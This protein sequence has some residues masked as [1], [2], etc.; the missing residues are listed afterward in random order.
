[1]TLQKK[2]ILSQFCNIDSELRVVIATVAL[3][4]GV[5]C[6]DVSQVIHFRS[7]SNLFSYAQEAGRCG[8]DGTKSLESVPQSFTKINQSMNRKFVTFRK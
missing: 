5:N 1:M 4:M 6:P 8:G 7:P 3:G 2:S